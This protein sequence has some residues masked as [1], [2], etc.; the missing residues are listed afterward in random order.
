MMSSPLYKHCYI[1]VYALTYD[2]DDASP[3]RFLFPKAALLL[4]L[5][6]RTARSTLEL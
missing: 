3:E 5:E 1:L 4:V 2:Y 6:L